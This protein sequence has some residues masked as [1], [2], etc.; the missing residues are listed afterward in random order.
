MKS[1][2]RV[3]LVALAFSMAVTLVM[4]DSIAAYAY[5]AFGG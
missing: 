4:V 5:T 2:L 3:R 1:S